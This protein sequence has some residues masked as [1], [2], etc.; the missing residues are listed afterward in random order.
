MSEVLQAE[1]QEIKA[2]NARVEADKAWERSHFRT[3]CVAVLTYFM[4]LLLMR[5]IGV[6][7]PYLAALVPTAGFALSTL[8]LRFAKGFW[9]KNFYK[10]AVQAKKG[11]I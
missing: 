3:V 5:M 8:S 11:Q 1:I 6:E 10:A 9:T 7:K 2:R 4:V